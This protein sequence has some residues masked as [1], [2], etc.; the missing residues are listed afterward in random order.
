MHPHAHGV[1]ARAA[2]A[3]P[4]A[5]LWTGSQFGAPT[6]PPWSPAPGVGGGGNEEEEEEEYDDDDDAAYAENLQQLHVRGLRVGARSDFE[7]MR[8]RHACLWRENTRLRARVGA[9]E[10]REGKTR[11]VSAGTLAPGAIVAQLNEALSESQADI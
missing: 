3:A 4:A 10:E 5:P 2:A 1:A 8:E 6:P 11:A 9:M 7:D